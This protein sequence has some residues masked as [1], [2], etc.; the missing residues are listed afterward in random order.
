MEH[1]S[2]QPKTESEL[3]IANEEDINSA[4][5]Y[6]RDKNKHYVANDEAVDEIVNEKGCQVIHP[7]RELKID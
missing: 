7:N 1:K 2:S 6:D 4:L 5:T 3:K